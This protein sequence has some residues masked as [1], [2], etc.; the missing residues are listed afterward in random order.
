MIELTP[1]LQALAGLIC[2]IITAIIIPYIKSKTDSQQLHRMNMWVQI[3]VRAAEQIFPQL[4]GSEKKAYVR[5]CL[6][7]RGFRLDAQMTDA[8][9]E[10]AVN[11]MNH[12]SLLIK[13][14]IKHE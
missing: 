11:I 3:A 6:K 4:C 7:N 1:I 9:I 12:K 5:Q 8:L 10:S 2:A 13:G 14:T